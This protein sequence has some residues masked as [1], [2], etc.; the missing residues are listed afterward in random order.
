MRDNSPPKEQDLRPSRLVVS[1]LARTVYATSVVDRGY[2]LFDRV[3]S[4]MV[5]ACASEEFYETF[6][7]LSFGG[8]DV[9]RP[10]TKSFRSWL[11]PF[12]ERAISRYFPSPPAMVLVGAAGGGREAFVLARRGYRIVAFDPVS[13]LAASLAH[14]CGELPI[15]VLVGRYEQLP[16]VSSLEHPAVNVDLRSRA[17]F[18]AA[19]LGLTSFSNLRSNHHRVETL[20]QFGNLTDG[21]ILVSYYRSQFE[22]SSPGFS[23]NLG[24]YHS[25][26]STEF[27]AL[28]EGAAL[29][30]ID[31][32][33][34][35]DTWGNAVLRA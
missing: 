21:P 15:E 1:L 26:S 22:G 17:P 6:N 18:A 29:K 24:Y 10:G 12:E 31:L 5:L 7:D 13:S 19:I 34:R 25:F 20:K 16:L 3:R 8:Q 23:L 35:P 11:F 30:I 9:Y 27:R 2:H 32:E 33:D 4:R 14:C 28:A